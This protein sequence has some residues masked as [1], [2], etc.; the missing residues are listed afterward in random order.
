VGTTEAEVAFVVADEYQSHGIGSLLL[1]ELVRAA[2]DRDIET[3][4]ADTLS[5]N[6]SMLGVFMH[7]GF[8]VKTSTECGTVSLRFA[9]APT[10]T[11][12]RALATREHFLGIGCARTQDP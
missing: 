3:F 10:E 8:E 4:L 7:A 9:I 2:R 1:D 5:E 11:S 6:H 12:R